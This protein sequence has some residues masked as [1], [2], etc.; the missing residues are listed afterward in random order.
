MDLGSLSRQPIENMYQNPEHNN[1]VG[2]GVAQAYFTSEKSNIS[3]MRVLI[4]KEVKEKISLIKYEKISFDCCN[5]T[6][7]KYIIFK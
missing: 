5:Y 3:G 7:Q 6:G 2:L 1:P 4:S